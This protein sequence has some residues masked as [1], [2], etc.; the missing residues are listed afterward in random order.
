MIAE[1][2]LTAVAAL[3]LPDA[4]QHFATAGVP[5]FPLVPGKKHPLVAHGFKDA[6]IDPTQVA[7]WWERWPEANIGIPTGPASGFEVVDVDVKGDAPRGP[8]SWQRAT[9]AGLLDGW[10]AL[11]VTPSGGLHAYY[12]AAEVEQRCWASGA[13]QLDFRGTAGYIVAPPSRIMIGGEPVAY[14]LLE[15]SAGQPFPVDAK[16]LR[17]FLDPRPVRASWPTAP[18]RGT[19]EERTRRI[20]TWLEGQG[21]GQRNQ[22]LYW[23][24]CRLAENEVSLHAALEALGPVAERI[25]LPPREIERTIRSAYRSPGAAPTPGDSTQN[26]SAGMRH[27]AT[28]KGRMLT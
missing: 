27:E 24:S 18:F 15:L 4:A 5:V 13:A 28:G 3:A 21:E 23:A 16:A 7:A 14:E 12:P 11:V 26:P 19:L 8:E 1:R 22:G 9:H 2:L 17:E 20:A 6:S 10:A 25:G